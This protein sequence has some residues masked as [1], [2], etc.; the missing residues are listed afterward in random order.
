MRLSRTI[1]IAILAI[2]VALLPMVGGM[3]AAASVP[4]A[5]AADCCHEPGPC[6]D[7]PAVGDCASITVWIRSQIP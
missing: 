3:A 2:A 7:A 5:S 1:L 4:A 6:D